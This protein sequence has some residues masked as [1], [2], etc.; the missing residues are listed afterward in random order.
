M[1]DFIRVVVVDV[2][3]ELDGLVLLVRLAT[4]LGVEHPE[5]EFHPRRA[6]GHHLVPRQHLH[7]QSGLFGEEFVVQ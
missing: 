3:L 5:P 6:A 4:L 7:F 1:S 2:E